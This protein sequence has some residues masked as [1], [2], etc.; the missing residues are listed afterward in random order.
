M[1]LVE[2]SRQLMRRQTDKNRAPAWSLTEIAIRKG[3]ELSKKHKV[4]ERL[5]LASLYLAHTAF[6]P[7]WKGRVQKNHHRLSS[8]LAKQYLERWRVKPE[9]KEIILNS[10]EAHHNKIPA[11]SLV[12][13][14]V[15]NAEC[16]K[17]VTVEGC[18]VFLHELG[19]R[20]VPFNEAAK[21]VIEKMEQK[22]KLLTLEDCK[23]ESE[24]NCKRIL[25]L[26]G[27]LER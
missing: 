6:S 11:R 24:E 26:F 20:H 21:M 23:K 19:S 12:A 17:F 18:L 16:F 7:V 13:E 8:E 27:P 10:I 2:K 1:D 25:E 15:K 9:E 3:T 14:V 4:D 22:R 5:V